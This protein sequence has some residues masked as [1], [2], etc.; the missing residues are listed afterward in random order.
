MSRA[1]RS[2]YREVLIHTGQHYDSNMSDIFFTELHIPR[3]DYNLGVG[4]GRQ[5]EQTGAI[6]KAVEEVLLQEQPDAV[7]VYGDTNST[8]G[9]A[10]AAA[11]L[12]IPVFHIEAGLRSFNREMPEEINRVLTDHLSTLLFCPTRTAVN[13]LSAEG[14]QKGVHLSGDVMYDAFRYNSRLARQRLSLPEKL[15][16][17]PGGYILGT[18]HRAENTDDPKRLKGIL[19]ALGQ[20]GIPVILPLH[21]RTRKVMD[22]QGLGDLLAG[23]DVRILEPV[24]YLDMICLEENARKI[25][26]D[27]GG[28]QKEAYFAGVPCITLRDETEWTETVAAGWNVLVGA[29][30]QSILK[31]VTE[32]AP[33]P[34]RPQIF[35]DG[36]AAGKF[37]SILKGD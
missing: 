30:T 26:T 36:D 31:A 17:P 3:P 6:L 2:V 8:L 29:D 35:G 20:A 32:F 12:H 24:G 21:P 19:R 14:I 25:L 10:L 5:G 37:L 22:D 11:K 4:S 23:S 27:S 15:G 7:L 16:L 33:P 18:I 1:L 28:V 13:N 34:E 9:G